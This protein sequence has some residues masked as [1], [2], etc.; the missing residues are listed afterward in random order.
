MSGPYAISAIY[1]DWQS[2]KRRHRAAS[3]RTAFR[4]MQHHDRPQWILRADD[5]GKGEL[6]SFAVADC[7]LTKAECDVTRTC[8]I[9]E[10]LPTR[11]NV[12][13]KR[14]QGPHVGMMHAGG[15]T[16]A[17]F[18]EAAMLAFGIEDA[19]APDERATA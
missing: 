4:S 3:K 1:T 12:D 8:T 17:W 6:R 11:G 15:Q 7:D 16:S 14:Q 5:M 19:A 18:V 13:F 10:N 9:I 2:E